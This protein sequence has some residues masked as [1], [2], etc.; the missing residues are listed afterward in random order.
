[1]ND[2]VAIGDILKMLRSNGV[3]SFK[4]SGIEVE[5]GE[6]ARLDNPMQASTS[7]HDDAPKKSSNAP[8]ELDDELLFHSAP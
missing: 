7:E 1:M 8:D 2:I 3:K 6:H 5:F 4:G